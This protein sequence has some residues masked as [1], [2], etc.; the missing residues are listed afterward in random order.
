MILTRRRLV[1]GLGAG[2]AALL[3]RSLPSAAQAASPKRLLV[4]LMP[5]CSNRARWIPGGGRNMAT[6]AGDAAAFTLNQMTEPF[7]PVRQHLTLVNGLDLPAIAGDQHGSAWIRFLTGGTIRAGEGAGNPE[8]IPDD[9]S[10]AA[11]PSIDQILL[12]RSPHLRGTT[13]LQLA[14]D[15]RSDRAFV[16]SRTLSY[17]VRN[18]P[19]PPENRPHETYRRLFASLA[20]SADLERVRAQQR[21]V[22]DYVRGDLARLAARVPAADRARLDQHLQGIRELERALDA[23]ATA[24]SVDRPAALP[25]V[26]ANSSRNHPAIVDNYL[27]TIRLAFQLDLARV[28]TF[29]FGGANS[30]V[31]FSEFDS[32][33]ANHWVH[34][35]THGLVPNFIDEMTRIT[36]W[37]VAR[38]AAFAQQLAATPDVGGG[39]VLDNTLIVFFCEIGTDHDHASIPIAMLGGSRLG[40]PGNRCLRYTGYYGQEIWRPVARAFGVELDHVGDPKY[41][42]GFLPG[43]FA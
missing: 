33:F 23:A 5:N 9:G 24:A 43:L 37:Y 19:L 8:N 41:T 6:G 16:A 35:V 34:A 4:I 28:V 7:A 3:A 15:T 32:T 26:P 42:K 1:S 30:Y 39:S 2:T 13:S 11:L 22:L 40:L 25:G 36:R 18:T 14:A 27:T 17:D 21:S 29:A 10:M 12:D 31:N 38:V 20:P